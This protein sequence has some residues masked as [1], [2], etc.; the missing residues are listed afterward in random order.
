MQT[1]ISF[2]LAAACVAF[3][4]SRAEARRLSA[5]LP[6]QQEGKV[7]DKPLQGSQLQALGTRDKSSLSPSE[8]QGCPEAGRAATGRE[9]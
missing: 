8:S 1:N 9:P 7:T 4:A 2:L 6:G 5:Q 3:Q